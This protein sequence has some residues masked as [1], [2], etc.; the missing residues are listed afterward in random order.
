MQMR[1]SATQRK[2]L[3]NFVITEAVSDDV[4]IIGISL[5]LYFLFVKPD[6]KSVRCLLIADYIE[7]VHYFRREQ[8][9]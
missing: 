2:I 6:V 3:N 9:P 5:A 7:I 4:R 1:D 8:F